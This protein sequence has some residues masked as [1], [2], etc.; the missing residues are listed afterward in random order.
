MISSDYSTIEKGRDQEWG[1]VMGSSTGRKSRRREETSKEPEK[2]Q[3][4]RM[5]ENQ[6]IVVHGSQ[7][8]KKIEQRPLVYSF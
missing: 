2:E 6:D 1:H 5:E 3:P 8:E 4:V 7:G